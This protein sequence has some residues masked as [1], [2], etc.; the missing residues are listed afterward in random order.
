M[1]KL[2]EM[3][4]WGSRKSSDVSPRVRIVARSGF[5]NLKCNAEK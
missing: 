3:A 1:W 4:N 5:R 2:R